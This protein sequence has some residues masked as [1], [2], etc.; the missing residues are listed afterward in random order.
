MIRTIKGIV[1]DVGPKSATIETSGLGYEVLVPTDTALRLSTGAE[2]LL[3][4]RLVIREDSHE[5]FGF[6]TRGELDFFEL[7]ISV[8]GVG[9][10]GA[11]TIIS[12]G[13]I[14]TL[15]KAIG[16]GDLAYLTK[17]SGIGKKTAEKIVVELRDKLA[18]LGHSASAGELSGEADS[19]AALESLGYSREEARD[20][21]KDVPA[22]FSE[23]S[24]R[25]REAL[26]ILGKK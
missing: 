2:I 10:R 11:M 25:I 20:A 9:P 12:I 21:L 3:H 15:K 18:L 22:L 23:P 4:T 1:T 13:S 24:S 26:K 14:D 19:L 7:L 16:S 17:V 6:E 8:S 5:L